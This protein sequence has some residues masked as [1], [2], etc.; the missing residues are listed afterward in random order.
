MDKIP[1]FYDQLHQHPEIQIMYIIS[2]EGTLITGDYIGRFQSGNVFVMGS[3]QPH[4]FRCDEEF[5]RRKLPRAAQSISLYFS[6]KYFGKELWNSN[7]LTAVREFANA[8]QHGLQIYDPASVEA[9]LLLEEL[10]QSHGLKKLSGFITLLSLI[11]QTPHKK[12]LSLQPGYLQVS[13]EGRMNSI[14][15]FT[16]RESHRKIYL[17]EVARLANLS[18]EAFCRYFKLHTRKTYTKFVNEVRVSQACQCLIQKELSV[19]QV[20]YKAG[21]SN[22]SNFN[23]I[24]RKITGKTPLAFRN[25]LPIGS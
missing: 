3:G 20:C 13:E 8:C 2:G 9:A 22:V 11:I 14:V 21:F 23:R 17:E 1:Y 5:Y 16:F 7:E 18:V 6:E 25:Q 15:A 4:V 12:K 10:V 24:F 19:Q